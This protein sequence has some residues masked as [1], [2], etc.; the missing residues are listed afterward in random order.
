MPLGVVK[1]RAVGVEG[2]V[3]NDE[4]DFKLA[5]GQGE[6]VRELRTVASLAK[7]DVSEA[8]VEV[9]EENLQIHG[10]LGFTWE[11]DPHLYLKRARSS[12]VLL[13]DPAYHRARTATELLG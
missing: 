11:Q 5:A 9:A 6:G 8:F 4:G 10:G 3:L 2:A 13:G 7:A 1:E 12:H